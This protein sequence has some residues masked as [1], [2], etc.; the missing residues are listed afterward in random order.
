MDNWSN[1]VTDAFALGWILSGAYLMSMAWVY[2]RN[3]GDTYRDTSLTLITLFWLII[4]AAALI[5]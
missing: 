5:W 4:A 3:K 2:E 1:A